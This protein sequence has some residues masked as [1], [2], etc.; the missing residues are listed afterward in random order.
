[1]PLAMSLILLDESS[2]AHGFLKQL[3]ISWKKYDM[4]KDNRNYLILPD[5]DYQS[6][7]NLEL[8]SDHIS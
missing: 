2:E 8:E 3:D 4:C 6:A 1:M 5:G 7:A